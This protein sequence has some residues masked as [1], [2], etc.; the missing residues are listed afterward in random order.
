[1]VY[2]YINARGLPRYGLVIEERPTGAYVLLDDFDY[3]GNGNI[4]PAT[5]SYIS[6]KPNTF[7]DATFVDANT[8]FEMLPV[9]TDVR[10]NNP[11]IAEAHKAMK[12]GTFEDWWAKN[13]DD[14][15]KQLTTRE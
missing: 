6:F 9:N 5:Y 15:K 3:R 14:L 2:R 4:L 1:M 7:V 10:W 12:A 11:R 13:G 8:K